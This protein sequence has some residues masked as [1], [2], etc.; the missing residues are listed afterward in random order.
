[1]NLWIFQ[2]SFFLST[3]EDL[4]P[5]RVGQETKRITDELDMRRI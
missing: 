2:I 1:M 5:W 4:E 3:G